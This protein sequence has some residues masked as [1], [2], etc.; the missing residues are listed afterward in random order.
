[1]KTQSTEA[2]RNNEQYQSNKARLA[3]YYA[4]QRRIRPLDIDWC[5][6]PIK[7]LPDC[8]WLRRQAD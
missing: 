4:K 8:M 2:E 3:A 7:Y 1:M 6:V 5:D